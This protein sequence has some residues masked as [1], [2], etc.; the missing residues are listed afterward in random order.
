MIDKP[1]VLRCGFLFRRLFPAQVKDTHLTIKQ[2]QAFG[3][4]KNILQIF[5]REN[6]HN[7]C[8]SFFFVQEKVSYVGGMEIFQYL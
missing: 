3:S 7:L 5:P 1:T 4:L 8:A 6:L 2:V